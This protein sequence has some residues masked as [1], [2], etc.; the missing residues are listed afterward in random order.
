MQST[1]N[2]RFKRIAKSAALWI[3][4]LLM[5]LG[6]AV[7]QRWTGPT[8]PVKGHYEL[9][10]I[11]Y[12]YK[13]T[14][15]HGG[16]GNQPVSI[17]APEDATGRIIWRFYP[18]DRPWNT[19][20]MEN[21]GGILTGYL[22]HQP[23]AGK[24]E[25]RVEVR[26]GGRLF[27]L[28]HSGTHAIT[29]FK[30]DVPSAVLIPHIILMFAGML[31]ST[32]AGLEAW[33]RKRFPKNLTMITLLFFAIGGLTLGC[34]I[35]NYAFGEPWTGFPVGHDLTDNK[36][37][38]AVLAWLMPLVVLRFNRN[39]RWYVTGAA[40]ITLIIFI[41]PHSMLGSQLDYEQME[42]LNQSSQIQSS[43]IFGEGNP[44]RAVASV[45]QQR[46]EIVLHSSIHSHSDRYHTLR[47]PQT[48][49][50]RTR[51]GLDGPAASA[52]AV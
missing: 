38:L 49:C 40:L 32:R 21:N 12:F 1:A 41:I 20:F 8:Y 15:S 42:Q 31:T 18:T 36:L 34:I 14:R 17:P 43:W 4:A 6:S 47:Y 2:N 23:P 19:E 25:Y 28:P 10:G 48:E 22:P 46:Y 45:E 16:P 33:L 35:Q 27:I 24:L 52:R 30:G 37:A 3:L 5:T 51:D 29:R 9:N 50:S 7:Y 11:T 39:P 13:L 26:T 44:D